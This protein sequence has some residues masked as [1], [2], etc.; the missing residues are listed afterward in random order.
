MAKIGAVS[1]WVA[2]RLKPLL[3]CCKNCWL[4]PRRWVAASPSP[5]WLKPATNKKRPNTYKVMLEASECAHHSWFVVIKDYWE[6]LFRRGSA[7]AWWACF[8]GSALDLYEM[9]IYFDRKTYVL[10]KQFITCFTYIIYIC[11]YIYTYVYI[12]MHI[13][14]YIYIFIHVHIHIIYICI[15]T[16]VFIYIYKYIH[17][18]VYIHI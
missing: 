8:F 2:L 5:C 15:C 13:I 1:S 9:A 4:L 10:H 7:I 11:L 18:C 6:A 17:T 3:Q 14:M 16:Y 12:C